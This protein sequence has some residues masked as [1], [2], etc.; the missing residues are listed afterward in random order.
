MRRGNGLLAFSP[1]AKQIYHCFG[2]REE[3]PEG[4]EEERKKESAKKGCWRNRLGHKFSPSAS[5]SFSLFKH[6]SVALCL[7]AARCKDKSNPA[8]VSQPDFFFFFAKSKTED[9]KKKVSAKMRSWGKFERAP[10]LPR[11]SLSPFALFS[12]RGRS[13]PS[14]GRRTYECGTLRRRQAGG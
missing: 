1:L 11:L 9:K 12:P 5:S 10:F 7:P 2:E 3:S 4:I 13:Q 6:G 14:K 8:K